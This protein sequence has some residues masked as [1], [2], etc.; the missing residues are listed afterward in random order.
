MHDPTIVMIHIIIGSIGLLGGFVSLFSTKGSKIHKNGG[1]IFISGM[2]VAIISTLMF[3][4]DNFLPLAII[5]CIA[6]F[7]LMVSAVTTIRVKSRWAITLDYIFLIFPL[8]LFVFP[9]MNMM[10]NLPDFTFVSLGQIVLSLTFLYCV[11]DDVQYL[12]RLKKSQTPNIGRHLFKMILAFTFGIMAVLRIGVKVDFIDLE[13]TVI[14]PLI[15]GMIIALN[16]K[17][18]FPIIELSS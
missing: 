5:M 15:V 14:V 13:F 2:I 18:K 4:R 10:R 8:V 9:L 11:I 12:R 17:R 7:Y 3:M 16:M 6:S 1:W